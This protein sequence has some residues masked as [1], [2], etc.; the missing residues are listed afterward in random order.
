MSFTLLVATH[1]SILTSDASRTPDGNPSQAYGTLRYRSRSQK[2]EVRR[3]KFFASSGPPLAAEALQHLRDR[4]IF[5][6]PMLP[7]RLVD[8]TQVQA[9][10]CPN[11]HLITR[12]HRHLQIALELGCRPA[13]LGKPFRD[14]R[15]DRFARSPQL[16]AQRTLLDRRKAKALTMDIQ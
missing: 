4:L 15:A 10:T 12:S 7:R 1:V 9:I 6:S 16:I 11:P 13:L 5:V 2:T 14:V 8:M 3:Q